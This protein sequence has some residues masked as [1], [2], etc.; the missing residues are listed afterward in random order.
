MDT[1]TGVFLGKWVIGK[2]IAGGIL[3]HLNAMVSVAPYQKISGQV[4]L[5]QATNPPLDA[6]I[7]VAG[8]YVN[9]TIGGTKVHIAIIRSVPSTL[10]GAPWLEMLVVWA[11]DWQTGT[12]WYRAQTGSKHIEQN[13]VPVKAE[14]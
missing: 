7:D 6:V 12:A 11:E 9:T 14:K 8:H 5:T 13:D 4:T 2:T 3:A 1:K 10:D